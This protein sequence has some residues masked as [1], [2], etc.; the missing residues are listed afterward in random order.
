MLLAVLDSSASQAGDRAIDRVSAAWGR[1]RAD[2]RGGS[3]W[4]GAW[5][6]PA[7]V[8]IES[9]HGWI[10][11]GWTDL[12]SAEVSPSSLNDARG[13]FALLA[14]KDEGAV[15]LASGRAGGYRPIFVAQPSRE[16]VIACTR[17]SVLLLLL[18]EKPALDLEYLAGAALNDRPRRDDSTPYSSIKRMPIGEGWLVR[19]GAEPIRWSTFRP[20][21]EPELRDDADLPH[22]LR[23]AVTD[24]TR[25]AMRGVAR[26]GVEVSG[27]LDSSFL[28]S[29]LVSLFHAGDLS[30]SPE[31]IV[32]ECAAPAWH[33]DRPHLRSL[34]SHLGLRAR[35][36]QPGDA[37]PFVHGPLV[38]DG[39]PAPSPTLSAASV[40]G[41]VARDQGVQVVLTGVGGDN[42]LDGS[43]RLFADL[44]RQGRICAALDGALRTRGVFH[45]GSVGR[46]DRFLVRPLLAPI[47]PGFARRAVQR[48]R[49]RPP[50]WAG[51]GVASYVDFYP[52]RAEAPASLNDSPGARYSSLLGISLFRLLALIHLQEEVV[53]G[54]ALRAPLLDDDFLRFVAT[55]PPLSLMRGGYLRGLMREAM[56]GLV[57][58]DLRLR[59]TKGHP[60]WFVEQTLDQGG[61]LRVFADLADVS[62]LADLRLIEPKHF[63]KVFD[64]CVERSIDAD[65]T[66]LWQVLSV[67]AFLRQYAG[68][69]ATRA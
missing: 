59:V 45:H 3:A 22:R 20:L 46:F 15:L 29:L 60:Y 6:A 35:R 19:P 26:A 43:P 28:L 57:P 4:L 30:N 61:G 9:E 62:M 14:L 67:E 27:G 44:A 7:G 12:A 11:E 65:F 49:R 63:R 48:I 66:A 40:V 36:V 25:A 1:P 52:Q 31:A 68:D 10:A 17:L 47:L 64:Q 16:V 50:R 23:E 2:V 69:G 39:M 51:P 37:A 54:Y 38:V 21:V 55:L 56:R 53:G 42:V 41:S 24:A 58:E 18:R 32:Y 33:D 5:E 13:D 8:R 34:E